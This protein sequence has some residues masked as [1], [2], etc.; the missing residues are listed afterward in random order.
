MNAKA[1][2][3]LSISAVCASI[4]ICEFLEQYISDNDKEPS[5]DGAI[6]IY[7]NK[8]K[9]KSGI[10]G[11]VPVQVKGKM[12]KDF[13]KTEIS[14]PV[15]IVDMK[16][17]LYDGGAIYFVVYV[18]ENG[19]ETKIYYITLPPVKL[20]SYI[21][22]ATEQAT[23]TLKLKEFPKDNDRKATIFLNFLKGSKRQTSFA[24]ADILSLEDL[25]K[26]GSLKGL[27]FSVAGYGYKNTIEDRL[28][29]LVE[30]EVYL[31][32]TIQGSNIP[33]PIDIIPEE[34]H[35]AEKVQSNISVGKDTYYKEFLR[36]RSLGKIEIKIG[37]SFSIIF[38]ENDNFIEYSYKNSPMLRKRAKD[39]EFM[40]KAIRA[41]E[42]FINNEELTAIPIDSKT[43]G[44]NIEMQEGSLEYYLKMISVLETLN[45]TSDINLEELTDKECADFHSLITAFVDKQPV[46]SLNSDLP[47]VSYIVVGNISF[48]LAF[49]KCENSQNLYNISD[50][51]SSKMALFYK[52]EEGNLLRTSLYSV[53]KKEGYIKASNI[54]YDRVLSSYQLIENENQHISEF[55]NQDMLM[56]LLA[57]DEVDEKNLDLLKA[58]KDLAKWILYNE[59]STISDELKLLNYL[60]IIR[61]ERKFNKEEIS[62][63]RTII[64]GSSMT[65]D[66]V[67]ASYILLGNQMAAEIS[68]E[69][70][71]IQLQNDFKE[72][73]IYNLW[74]KNE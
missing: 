34:L 18:S 47:S 4:A 72:Y 31:Y 16:N 70:M 40:I 71:S 1:I 52:D 58:A 60:Q 66:V 39:L 50:F 51:F 67:T 21:A 57:Y 54:D 23:K 8:N 22:Q 33:H 53:L 36:T 28:R 26:S 17:Y 2:E 41:G 49:K 20:K 14:F 44:F 11:R 63:L 74:N 61:R 73:P 59:K 43:E 68:F 24:M 38:R 48:L 27:S 65:E 37:D 35:I 13:S 55:A 6:Y 62:Q 69:K 19:V 45:V 30:N 46:K 3:T 12:S 64:Q 32:A 9:K 42:F 5:W 15:S 29:A 56:M 7:N 25:E 10:N